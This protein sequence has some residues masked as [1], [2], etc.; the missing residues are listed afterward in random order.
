M[1]VARFSQLLRSARY[2]FSKSLK[3]NYT[4]QKVII[5]GENSRRL[6]S[7]ESCG[8]V[9]LLLLSQIAKNT[10]YKVQRRQ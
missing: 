3:S 9:K 5:V 2:V 7:T 10:K 4:F 6:V 1:F 8:M